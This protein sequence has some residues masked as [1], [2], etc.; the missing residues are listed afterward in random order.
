MLLEISF[1]L[2]CSFEASIC[3]PR[4]S[5]QNLRCHDCKVLMHL[6]FEVQLLVAEDLR[7]IKEALLLV[8]S[9]IVFVQYLLD[10]K[11]LPEYYKLM[12]D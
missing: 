7:D 10:V 1:P 9:L 6:T 3:L 5:L 8:H 2:V 11:L 4:S 12:I